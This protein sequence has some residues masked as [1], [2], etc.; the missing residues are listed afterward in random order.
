MRVIELP[1]KFVVVEVRQLFVVKGS[2]VDIN[3]MVETITG[4]GYGKVTTGTLTVLGFALLIVVKLGIII[5][6]SVP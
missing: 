1:V 5:V 2:I 3:G 6:L 4:V